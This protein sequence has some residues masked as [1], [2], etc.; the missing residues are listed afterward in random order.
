M[1]SS[2][3]FRKYARKTPGLDILYRW[4]LQKT[5]IPFEPVT[6]ETEPPPGRFSQL[7]FAHEG[8]EVHKWLHYCEIYDEL[9]DPFVSRPRPADRPIRFLEIGVLHG[10]S[11]EVW[12]K[13]FGEN[14]TVFGIDI[15]PACAV[16]PPEGAAVRTGSQA[17]SKFLESVIIEMGGVDI[18]LD[19]GCHISSIQRKTFDILF[20]LL[21]EGGLYVVEDTSTSYAWSFGGGFRR[22]GTVIQMA[23]G[24]VDG[25][26]KSYFRTR[27]GRRGMLAWR[28]V[29]NIRFFE[30]II[31]IQKKRRVQPQSGA[32]GTTNLLRMRS[33]TPEAD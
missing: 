11:L 18:I 1:S 8:R 24:M 7:L 4:I 19:D 10:G 23:K 13:Y 21:N 9:F 12:L 30:S 26:H 14:A 32:F 3:R 25:M 28:E 31:S 22:P 33:L 5:L 2:T 17:D 15:D 29:G 27:V 16:N 20:P 6:D